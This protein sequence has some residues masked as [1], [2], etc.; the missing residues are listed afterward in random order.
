MTQ[1]TIYA[2]TSA[3]CN[4]LP[5]AQLLRDSLRR[6][7]PEF[8]LVLALPDRLPENTATDELGW[9]EVLPIES[10][11]IRDWKTWAFTHAIVELATAIK[12]VALEMLLS[13]P[14]CRAVVYFDPDMVL[15][16]RLDDLVEQLDS[17]DI[18]LTP[19]QNRPES[20]LAEV[21]DNE[22]SSLKHGIYNLGFIGVRLTPNGRQFAR[23]WAERTYYFCQDDIPNGLF[24]DQ[25]WMD[26]APA[27]FSG[28]EIM[29]N[30]RF[31][32]A[33]WNLT[34]RRLSGGAEAGY[35]VDDKPL[36]FYHFTGFD[37]GAHHIMTGKYGPDNA[38]V[39]ELV[40]WYRKTTAGLADS[41]LSVLP[42]AYG[43]YADDRPIPRAH[44]LIYRCRHDLQLRYPDPFQAGGANAATYA[45]WCETAG[46]LE[47]PE[48]L[49]TDPS[50][51]D[52]RG[53]PGHLTLSV[54]PPPGE[55]PGVAARLKAALGNPRVAGALVRQ[56]ASVVRRE[57]LGGLIARL[58]RL[59]GGR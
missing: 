44:R 32:V 15:F 11:G 5:K 35:Q 57:G 2:F 47:Y 54:A 42:W 53:F 30:S 6:F 12:P 26:L 18:L 31:N 20:G 8:R 41:P 17:A 19:H 48:L 4:Y 38:A 50:E 28:V 58:R 16:S 59:G 45:G 43:H 49:A 33:P 3:A 52:L 36:G 22:I 21:M 10:M 40:A 25:R 9:D 55:L 23:W 34:T 7:H 37:S 1:K 24:T 46:K 29:R 39:A 56:T 27:L 14:D 51:A 13:R